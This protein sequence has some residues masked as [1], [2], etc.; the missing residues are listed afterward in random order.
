[1]PNRLLL[2]YSMKKALQVY[3]ATLIILLF[4]FPIAAIADDRVNFIDME[5]D[6]YR[7]PWQSYQKLIALQSA[8]QS[9]DELTYLWW[10]LRKAQAENL[11]YFYDDFNR[12]VEQ[13]N[14]LVTGKTP[15]AIQA[16]LSLF[17]GLIHSRQG[18]YSLS[19]SALA[20]GL[21]QAKEAKL[22]GLYI[23]TKQE[24]AYTKTLTE[25]F[26]ASLE[27]IQEA[28][29]EAFA[30]KDQFLIASIN[31][32]YGAIYGYLNDYKKSIEYY[33]R[34]LEAY[35]NLEYP[36]HIAEALYGLASTYRYWKKYDLAIEYFDKYQQ[37]IDYTPNANISFFA[38]YGIGMTLAERGDCLDAI[39]VIDKALALKGAIDYN[40]ELYKRKA[41]CL[42]ALE[43][44]EE[45]ES[46]LF[47]AANIFANI[48]ELIGTSW[49]LEVIK[50]SSELAYA[51]GQ[52]GIGYGML[53]QYY[54]KY[55]ALLLKN[56][57][58]RLLKVRA[59][60][61][62]ERKRIAQNLAEK[63]SQVEML[64]LEK[65]E[66]SRILQIYFNIFIICVVLIVLIVITV[67]YRTNKKMHLISI[68]DP[69]SGLFNRRYIF[70][71]LQT[72]VLG[73]HP[74]KMTLSVILI[75]IDDFKKINDNYGHPMGDDVIRQI[76]E[77]G[78]DIFR[79][80]DIFGRI[81][82]EEFLCILPRTNISEATKI[83]QRFLALTNDSKM[84]A[85]HQETITVSIGIAALSEQCQDV[86]QLYINAD[87]ALYQAKNLGKN[88]VNVF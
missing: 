46:A 59:S 50:I 44:L 32:T 8:A 22:S 78:R 74:D 3:C 61:E 57:S 17:Q 4:S 71:Y 60:M 38:A 75:D 30:L 7:A 82:G 33:Q 48:P 70:D 21:I 6:I 68:N 80:D 24:L 1:M 54:Q 36:A 76:A 5:H 79:Q 73:S 14:A 51:R 43:L 55:T 86:K 40:A 31:E 58:Q 77:V 66:N 35:Q 85:G 9:Y 52:Y 41:S 49:Q 69:L 10:L 81:G 12:T 39:A 19:Q 88:Q 62:I 83:A 64:E 45:A 29:V 34:A 20:K 13:A 42:I 11:I 25:I 56:S 37:Q 53:E 72:A 23:F 65:R 26:D 18:N 16:H 15:L 87:Q 63:R 67:Q 2:G 28:Y 27:D 47:N 84:V